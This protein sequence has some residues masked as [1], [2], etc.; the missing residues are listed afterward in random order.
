MN[1]LA[2]NKALQAIWELVGAANKYIDETAPWALA[3]EE[4]L[5]P[6]LATVMYNLLEGT[7]LIALLAAPFLPET[8]ASILKTLGIP[9]KELQ[10]DGNDRWGL[11]P[12]G[13]QVA[14]AAPLFPRIE[15]E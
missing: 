3:K 12:P 5:R 15:T 4:S 8:G 2:F 11:L 10:L 7:R 13:T 14:K 9:V 6:R 1:E